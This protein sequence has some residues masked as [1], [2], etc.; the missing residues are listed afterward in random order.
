MPAEDRSAAVFDAAAQAFDLARQALARLAALRQDV[1]SVDD[2]AA[3]FQGVLASI[4]RAAGVAAQMKE[5]S[6]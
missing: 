2:P 1:K 6:P 3:L 5:A 4:A